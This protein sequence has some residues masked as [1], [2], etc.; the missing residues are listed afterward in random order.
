M[1][2]SASPVKGGVIADAEYRAPVTFPRYHASFFE[3]SSMAKARS[4]R[5]LVAWS[6]DD[7]K[8]LRA[9]AKSRLPGTQA[10]KKLRLSTGAVTQKAM[11]LGV[12]F[13]SVRKRAG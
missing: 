8:N 4:R 13:R 6:K 11:K 9:F 10:A 7:V 12:K 5:K 1:L 3:G 2:M